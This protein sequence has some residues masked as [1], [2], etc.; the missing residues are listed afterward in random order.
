[1]AELCA[2]GRPSILV[3]LPH[4][5]DNDQLE[6]AKRLEA[7]GGCWCLSQDQVTSEM[8]AGMVLRLFEEPAMLSTAA[9]KALTLGN[10]R[11]VENLADLIGELADGRVPATRLAAT[12]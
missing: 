3:P 1:V 6:N 12:A 10:F 8:L 5:K 4:A 2:L 9:H 11:A 7:L